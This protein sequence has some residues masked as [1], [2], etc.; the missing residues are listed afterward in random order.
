MASRNLLRRIA[1]LLACALLFAQLAVAA[2]ACPMSAPAGLIAQAAFADDDIAAGTRPDCH[3]DRAGQHDS[4]L[5]G[6]CAEHC[7]Q[8][9]QS[10][11]AHIAVAVPPALLN[12]LYETAAVLPPARGR[13]A[14][15]SWLSA[16]VA[17]SPPHAIAHCV[18]RI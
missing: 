8:G 6:V 10:D 13:P 16:L 11:R 5:T 2:H 4:T 3:D 18:L 15:G 12:A 9:Q 1:G 7:K 14:S 17:A